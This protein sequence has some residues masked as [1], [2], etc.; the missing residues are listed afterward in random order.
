M[1]KIKLRRILTIII[2]IAM[3]MKMVPGTIFH[4]SRITDH[5]TRTNGL[6]PMASGHK[7][8]SRLETV[9]RLFSEEKPFLV[10]DADFSVTDTAEW[11]LPYA[12]LEYKFLLKALLVS[13][14][15]KPMYGTAFALSPNE[16]ETLDK[17]I[18]LILDNSKGSI[19]VTSFGP[20]DEA[21][22]LIETANIIIEHSERAG[23]YMPIRLVGYEISAKRL[24]VARNNIRTFIEK[25]PEPWARLINCTFF[26][27]DLEDKQ[28]WEQMLSYIPSD[29]YI[30]RHNWLTGSLHILADE[31]IRTF[32][33]LLAGTVN[34]PG[35]LILCE[36]S[37]FSETTTSR[38]VIQ[39]PVFQP[40]VE[41]HGRAHVMLTTAIEASA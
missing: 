1:N 35:A 11:F 41:N 40:K 21:S 23:L 5:G 14:I 37:A 24:K 4:G 7:G 30:W 36:R 25:L 16:R 10:T 12:G 6:R 27:G 18:P 19:T 26:Y 2:T 20:G 28:H 9:V 34:I 8:L 13:H 15:K 22:E 33:Q 3:M 39:R 31:D 38:A 32:V 29:I 17:A